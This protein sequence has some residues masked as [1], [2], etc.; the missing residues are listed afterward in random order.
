[1]KIVK[2]S[3]CSS[4]S[5]KTYLSISSEEQFSLE[6]DILEQSNKASYFSFLVENFDVKNGFNRWKQSKHTCALNQGCALHSV[7]P[8][9]PQTPTPTLAQSLHQTLAQSLDQ[10]L[11]KV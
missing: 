3:V 11:L 9:L 4:Q 8:P 2:G 10:T 5:K 6:P 1:M 7:T